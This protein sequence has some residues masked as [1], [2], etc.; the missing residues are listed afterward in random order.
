MAIWEM[1][2]LLV[3]PKKVFKSIYYHVSLFNSGIC[4]NIMLTR[5]VDRN[6]RE[7]RPETEE[8]TALKL[9]LSI[10]KP[11]THG[12]DQIHHSPISSPSSSCSQHSHGASHIP[13]PSDLSFAYPF[14]SYSSTLSGRRCSYPPSPTLPSAD[15]LDLTVRLH[16]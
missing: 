6:V 13:P 1:T 5:C 15:C 4:S 9:M 14:S 10:Q 16:P 3:A 2:S 8:T 11:K 12:I 7:L